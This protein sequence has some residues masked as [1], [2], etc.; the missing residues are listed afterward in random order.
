LARVWSREEAEWQCRQRADSVVASH[1][2]GG[3]QRFL[4]GYI[5]PIAD[6][7]QT[8]CLLIEDVLW[9]DLAV[10]ERPVLVKKLVDRAASFGARIAV[11]PLLGYADMAAF[12]KARFLRSP[13]VLHAYFGLWDEALQPELVSSFYVDVF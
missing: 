3:G 5:M 1:S 10:E 13:R 12:V 7:A 2:A 6:R 4:T 11:V 8:K 9:N